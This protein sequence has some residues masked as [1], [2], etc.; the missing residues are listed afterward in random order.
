MAIE[1]GA[2]PGTQP[3]NVREFP[4]TSITSS[5]TVPGKFVSYYDVDLWQMKWKGVISVR[6]QK[7]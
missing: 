3:L 2:E 7:K 5:P 4:D 1:A 6:Q